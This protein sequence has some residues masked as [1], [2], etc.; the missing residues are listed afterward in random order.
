MG[1]LLKIPF[2]ITFYI[3]F[4][5]IAYLNKVIG[6]SIKQ[7]HCLN[8]GM[9]SLKTESERCTVNATCGCYFQLGCAVIHTLP[10][11][12]ERNHYGVR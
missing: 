1:I 11:S 5:G 12:D 9:M 6:I 2:S 10:R 8:V 7:F 4:L 3:T